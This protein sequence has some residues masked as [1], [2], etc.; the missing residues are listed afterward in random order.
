MLVEI[1]KELFNRLVP[2]DVPVYRIISKDDQYQMLYKVDGVI[3]MAVDY[4]LICKTMY[5]VQ[6][7]NA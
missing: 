4:Y 5:F 2:N 3:I 6:D 1:T 7:I